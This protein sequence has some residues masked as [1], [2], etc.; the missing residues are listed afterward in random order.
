MNPYVRPGSKAC[1]RTFLTIIKPIL[2]KA[3]ERNMF[4]R[5]LAPLLLYFLLAACGEAN[6]NNPYPAKDSQK[7]IHYSNFDS[8]P[9][10]LDPAK[11]YS[12]NEY[13]YLAQIYEPPL[14][15]HFLKRPY[16]LIPATSTAL[17]T[18]H[19]LDKDLQRLRN[20]A[21]QARI[22]YTVYT[23]SIQPG[24]QY[25]PHP[26]F[27]KNTEAKYQYHNLTADD[28]EAIYRLEDFAQTAT[29]ELTAADYVYQI[30][31]LAHPDLHSPI[32]GVMGDYIV[33]LRELA[34]ELTF[35]RKQQ[36]DGF[37]DLNDYKLEG[38]ELINKYT[39]SIRVKGLYPQLQ[40]W[41]AM[42][43]F[44]PIPVEADRFYSQPVLKKKNISLS[45]YPVGTGPYLMSEHNPNQRIVL[46]RN[47]N[48]HGEVYPSEGEPGDAEKGLL[49]DAG[50]PIPFIDKAIYSLEKEAIPSWNKFLQGYYDTSGIG[51]DSFDQAV[52]I[53]SQGEPTLTESMQEKGISLL[54]AVTTST[55]YTGF[56]MLDPVVGGDSERARK[57]RRAIAIAADFEE[58]ISIFA[59]G[60]GTAAQGPVP[61]GIYGN[62]E[63]ET[64]INPY[65]YDW[66]NGEP[67]RKSI[68][69]AKKLMVEAGYPEGRDAKTGEQ[70][71]L[72]LD[73]ASAGPDAKS[74]LNWWRKQMKKLGIEL[75]IRSTDYNRFQ[76]KMRTGKAQIFQW[77][78]NAD[79]PDP[80]NFMFLLYGPNGKVDHKGENAANYNNPEFDKLFEKMKSMPNSPERLA[81]IDQ[82]TEILRKDS[83]WLWGFHPKAFGLQHAW[84]R[85]NKPNLIANN[86]LKFK[87]ID[88]AMRAELR[89]QWNKPV[90]WP[91]YVLLG[92]FIVLLVPAVLVYRHH[93]HA[94]PSIKGGGA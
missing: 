81:I 39:Y 54:T 1:N 30:K 92:V 89:S 93:E 84:Y 64:G 7:N 11:S 40:Y 44:A 42:P 31:R 26:A 5:S 51:S 71:V 80:E 15:Y 77:G 33:G 24:I 50:K 90:L 73:N 6:W 35:V 63:G 91:I 23:I 94:T 14:Q 29:R 70:L 17:P 67:R 68:D 53:S 85:N 61:P 41:L 60:R 76:E 12:S 83:P 8:G 38:V 65:V 58:Y 36:P 13:Q 22:A 2:K 88:P 82:M 79:Y 66:L 32:Q 3:F 52:T 56:N 62:R 74:Q 43:F 57:L 47:P 37:L 87:R 25:Q 48:F 9:K 55:Y 4:G 16:T 34:K 10:T 78:W 69:V 27:V 19:F 86:T 59:N 72:Y 18:E 21:P 20:D 28:V 46:S 75:V 49:K 45:T